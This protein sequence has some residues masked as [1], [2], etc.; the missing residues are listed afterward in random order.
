MIQKPFFVI[1]FLLSSMVASSFSGII[2]TGTYF[3]QKTQK[4]D[5]D[6]VTWGGNFGANFGT[7]TYIDI[8]PLV[9]YYLTPQWVAGIGGSYIYYRQRFSPTAFYQTHLYGARAF[10]QYSFLPN[11]FAHGEME[12]MNFDHYDFLSG[13]NTRVWFPTPFLG[14]GYSIPMGGRATFRTMAL[15]AFN[16]TDPMSPYFNNPL[17]FRVGFLM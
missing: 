10:T 6:N 17:V 2:P 16:S 1:L 12:L 13:V 11:V 15:F 3:P 5:P 14:L 7:S 9:G 4:F 8:S